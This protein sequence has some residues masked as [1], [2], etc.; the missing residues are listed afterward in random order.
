MNAPRK[1]SITITGPEA[2][3]EAMANL[4]RS[5]GYTVVAPGAVPLGAIRGAEQAVLDAA[6]RW[7]AKDPRAHGRTELGKAARQLKVLGGR[8]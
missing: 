5:E 8:K 7:L 6:D 3:L 4:L 2:M 1:L